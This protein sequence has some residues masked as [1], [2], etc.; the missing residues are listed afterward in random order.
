MG[1]PGSIDVTTTD[2][3]LVIDSVKRCEGRPGIIE[4]EEVV[5]REK[6]ESMSRTS[7]SAYLPTTQF[8]SLS[9]NRT[10]AMEPEGSIGKCSAPLA[11][12]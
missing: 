10:V 11:S 3:P 9:P 1:N 7:L 8:L 12:R 5:W 4:S 2:N 6:E